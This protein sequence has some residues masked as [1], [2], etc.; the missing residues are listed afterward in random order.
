MATIKDIVQGLKTNYGD[1]AEIVVAWW[2]REW[3][4][5]M[6][7]REID[8][9]EWSVVLESSEKVLEYADLGDQLM[10]YAERALDEAGLP[11]KPLKKEEETK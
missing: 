4:E 8:D 3:F 7:D 2:D 11:A 9:E 5:A 10:S 1:D 6:L